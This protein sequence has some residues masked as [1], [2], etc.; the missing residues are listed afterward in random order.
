MR[1]LSP[2]IS[3]FFINLFPPLLFNRIVVKRVSKDFREVDVKVKLSF[4]NKNLQRTI[5][6]G[7][8]F[9]AAD[10]FFSLMYYQILAHKKIAAEAWVKRIEIDYL[11]PA[12]KDVYLNFRI[13]ETDVEKAIEGIEKYKKFEKIHNLDIVGTDNKVY[14]KVT[15]WVYLK[16][17]I[18]VL[19]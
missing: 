1:I 18:P 11:R 4:M 8:L 16:E 14:C 10:P 17:S 15:I 9:S 7:T 6:G 5:F 13:S 3:K 12:N 19:K 2:K